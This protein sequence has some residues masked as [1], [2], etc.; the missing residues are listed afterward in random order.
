M[1]CKWSSQPV[2]FSR[3]K[4]SLALYGGL[5]RTLWVLGLIL[6]CCGYHSAE[7]STVA[8]LGRKPI[9]EW[10]KGPMK[11]HAKGPWGKPAHMPNLSGA[12]VIL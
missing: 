8:G 9:S 4:T 3:P 12:E 1:T 2:I 5:L 7:R 10:F 6:T 11:L